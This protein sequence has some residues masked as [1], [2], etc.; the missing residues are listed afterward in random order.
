MSNLWGVIREADGK[1][2]SRVPAGTALP[3]GAV[4]LLLVP[5]DVADAAEPAY[6]PTTPEPAPPEPRVMPPRAF[7]DA[8]PMIRQQQ[9]T[10]IAMGTPQ[11][12]L[13]LLRMTA[14][15]EVDCDDPETITGVEA[16][17]DASVISPAEADA[18][19]RR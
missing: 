11:V 8:L 16:L 12:F 13:W 5:P 14:A 1:L 3:P 17:R 15:V 2:L 19:L 18:L 6:P 10:A 7:M 4:G 9:I